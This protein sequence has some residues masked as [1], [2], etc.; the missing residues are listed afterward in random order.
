M[1]SQVHRSPG[2]CFFFAVVHLQE[3]EGVND[4]KKGIPRHVRTAREIAL[5]LPAFSRDDVRVIRKSCLLRCIPK[6]DRRFSLSS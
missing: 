3:N 6:S 1:K 4:E 2:R 5:L